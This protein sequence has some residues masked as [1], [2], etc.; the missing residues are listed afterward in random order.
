MGRKA[1]RSWTGHGGRSS[2]PWLGGGDTEQACGRSGAAAEKGLHGAAQ[3]VGAMQLAMH[4]SPTT[5]VVRK[6]LGEIGE[7]ESERGEWLGTSA[8]AAE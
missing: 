6:L 5:R 7:S 4:C 8:A 2:P 1:S 3:S